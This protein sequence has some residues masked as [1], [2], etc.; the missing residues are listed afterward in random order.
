MSSAMSLTDWPVLLPQC[1]NFASYVIEWDLGSYVA[2]E[3]VVSQI[4]QTCIATI[5]VLATVYTPLAE[6]KKGSH[7]FV[8]VGSLRDML[9]A[10]RTHY[11]HIGARIQAR[12]GAASLRKRRKRRCIVQ[13]DCGQFRLYSDET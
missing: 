5:L 1:D 3:V 2:L 8:V 6:T 9:C 13:A 4:V 10:I 12:F 11:T 7:A